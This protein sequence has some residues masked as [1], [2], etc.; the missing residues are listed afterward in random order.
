MFYAA[1]AW[2]CARLPLFCLAA[3]LAANALAQVDTEPV[4]GLRER[5][6]RVHVLTGA[7]VVVSPGVV[8]ESA[9]VV[10]R[11]GLIDVVGD[12]IE[13]PPDARVWDLEG[14]V[15][16]AGFIDTM[17][18]LGLP[19]GLK[20]PRP[21]GEDDP[22][23]PEPP[24]Q[25]ASGFWNSRI[26]PELD[27]AELISLEEDEVE[28]L[29]SIG[30]TTVLSVPRAGILRGQSAAVS[31]A[32]PENARES[33]IAAGVAQHA[34]ADMG[35]RNDEYPDS[36]MGVIALLR[37]AFLDAGWYS[38]MSAYY[39][40]NPAAERPAANAALAALGPVLDRSQPLFYATDDEL[41]YARALALGA[42]MGLDVVLA[43]NGHEYRKTSL[44]AS[45][46]RPIIVP[47]DFPEPPD[48]ASPDSALDVTLET[49][50]HWELAPSNPAFLAAAG[51]EF[52]LTADGLDDVDE[53]FWKNLR[54]AVERG[55][56]A[57]TALAALTT[58]P[59]GLMDMTDTLGTLEGGKIANLV[60]A[61]GDLFS[62]EEA[63]IEIVF[64]DGQPY[65]LDAFD[66]PKPEGR[67]EVSFAARSAEWEI[68]ANDERLELAIGEEEYQGRIDG[69]R[70]L[71]FPAA[72]V[73]GVVDGI[74]R[75]T[76]YV[77][78]GA[79]D[80]LAE[81][82]NG[83]SFAWTARYLGEAADP[84]ETDAPD[85]EEVD[86][87]EA[88]AGEA[89]ADRPIPPL[90]F[91]SYPAG[92]YGISGP[93]EQ[94][95]T[96]LI[97]NA[98]IWTSAEAGVLE[99]ADLLVRAGR[100]EAIGTDLG[101]PRDAV[102]IDATGKHVTAGLVDA[103]SHTAISR[104]IN[105]STSAVTIEVRIEDVLDPTD[106]NIYRQLAGGLTTANVMHGSANPMG[107]QVRTIKLRWGADAAGLLF[108]DAPPGVKFALGEN[109]KQS[110][111][112]DEYTTRYPQTRMGVDEFIRDTFD[113]ALAYGAEQQG[114]ER[115][116]A[117]LRRNLR[118]DAA[119]EILDG[120]RRVHVHS[121]R[122]DEI[123]A[124]IRLAQE[125]SLDVAAFQ[126]VLE[127]YKVAPE[128]AELGA[129]AST[130]SD[131]WGFKV[132]SLDAIP[133]NGA[134]MRVAG[135]VVSFNSDDDELATRLNTEA[136]KAVRYGGV[137]EADALNFV[138]INP[139][140][141]LGIDDRVGSLE[142]GKDADFVIWSGHPL[143]TMTRAEQTWIDGRRYFDLAL[144]TELRTA[145]I[146]E[147]ARL[148]QRVLGEVL[149]ESE[150]EEPEPGPDAAPDGQ[151]F[152]RSSDLYGS[153]T[154][155]SHALGDDD[156]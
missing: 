51:I 94:P 49:L 12:E 68:R 109:V 141:Q 106:I 17:S 19:A 108:A 27:V 57:D 31:L 58:V 119:L 103:H 9:S 89:D 145:A 99:G 147:R 69:E 85:A 44:L 11:D 126:H 133:F 13:L 72:S 96:L 124:F 7:R 86:A 21:R 93:P 113:A 114:W 33:V 146:A 136:A 115:G 43:G 112:G 123:L 138:T 30:L 37:Q 153:L 84:D 52:A 65:P 122:Q 71:L 42:E 140:I 137:P 74:A 87:D 23:P 134:L 127:G 34:G 22:P 132:E 125:Y 88:G 63:A 150:P 61:D 98:T 64:V 2:P 129:G 82:P 101:A 76:G 111:W 121:Y 5:T 110:N 118:L 48:V 20:T 1:R 8:L 139:A 59:A 18:E 41:D 131:W 53:E 46:D 135:V 38:E 26:Q 95:A 155:R 91:A 152:R 100:I 107:G 120:T 156:E 14:R 130:F 151:G 35:G 39:T 67:W 24:R 79:I 102:I 4:T 47:L 90:V 50:Q 78:D 32:D 142:P 70:V 117:P 16:Y 3:L 40:A 143:A 6:P 77:D 128:I 60:V 10:L 55:L 62:D 29:R 144:D 66:A 92:E 36:L 81:L 83:D 45:L 73:F 149:D 116:D 75:L 54:L 104:G 25:A 154:Q 80:G 28:S 15:V 97:R 148:I 56:P 105:E